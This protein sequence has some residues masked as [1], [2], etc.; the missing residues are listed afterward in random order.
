M[1]RRED[2]YTGPKVICAGLPRTGT[3]SLHAALKILNLHPCLHYTL[4]TQEFFPYPQWR[5]WKKALTLYG[6]QHK[7][8]RQAI[9]KEIFE[10]GH[11]AATLAYPAAIFVEDFVEMFP[12]A[13]FIH[14]TRASTEVWKR[15]VDE[16]MRRPV[17]RDVVREWLAV[18]TRLLKPGSLRPDLV[19]WGRRQFGAGYCDVDNAR[20]Y[21]CY[22]EFVKEVVPA[23]RLLADFDPGLGWGPLCEFLD[24]EVPVDELGVPVEYP[25]LNDRAAVEYERKRRVLKGFISWAVVLGVGFGLAKLVIRLRREHKSLVSFLIELIPVRGL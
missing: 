9:L 3:T 19:E 18:W 15:S 25:R 20:L 12:E 23:G 17:R 24:M 16:G 4:I 14:T 7:S 5:R 21:E 6:E 13:K 10:R 11:Y 1:N 2:T 22:N 8:T